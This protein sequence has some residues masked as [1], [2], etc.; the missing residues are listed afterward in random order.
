V[1]RGPGRRAALAGLASL[2]WLAACGFQPIYAPGSP[3]AAM[4]GRVAIPT[5]DGAAGFALRER[6]VERLGVAGPGAHRLEIDLTVRQE[7]AAVTQDN[8]TTRFLVLGSAQFALYPPGGTTALLR[9]TVRTQTAYSA[10]ASDTASAY[11]ARTAGLDA[12]RRVARDL[13]DRMV[14]RL[15]LSAGDWLPGGAA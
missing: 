4:D 1:S 7:G 9:D 2:P 11:A 6:L 12:E 3:A 10:P 5:L 15:A 13:A 8:I 14:M